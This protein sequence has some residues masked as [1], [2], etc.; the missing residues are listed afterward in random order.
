MR[1]LH[2]MVDVVLNV[3][4]SKFVFSFDPA[5]EICEGRIFPDVGIRLAENFDSAK[6]IGR[7]C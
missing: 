3:G 2:D 4:G 5:M 7:G 1:V 6:K